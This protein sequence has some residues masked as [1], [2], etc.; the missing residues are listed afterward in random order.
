MFSY[1]GEPTTKNQFYDT[2][3]N[4]ASSSLHGRQ[5]P[6]SRVRKKPFFFKKKNKNQFSGLYRVLS[7]FVVYLGAFG[8]SI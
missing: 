6:L 5:S 3:V 8:F 7:G 1:S 2:V 4:W